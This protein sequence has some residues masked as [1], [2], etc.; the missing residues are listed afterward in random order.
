MR[1]ES[2]NT[3]D[4]LQLAVHTFVSAYVAEVSFNKKDSSDICGY[5]N[6]FVQKFS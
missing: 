2:W 1:S 3:V 4:C 6:L 5:L